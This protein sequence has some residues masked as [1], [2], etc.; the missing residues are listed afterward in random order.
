M[1][2][3]PTM[4]SSDRNGA[5]ALLA[6]RVTFEDAVNYTYRVRWQGSKNG[7]GA[8]AN[9]RSWLSLLPAG[10]YL[11]EIDARRVSA[12]VEQ[13]LARRL[14]GAT[15]NRKLSALGRVLT[16]AMQAGMIQSRPPSFPRLREK[17]GR[18][19][20]V[21]EAEVQQL[22]AHSGTDFGRLWIFLFDTGLR[23][24]EALSLTAADVD[25][26]SRSIVVRESKSGS[27]RTVPLTLRA[28]EAVQRRAIPFPVSQS[29]VNREWSSVRH[30]M[31]LT[32]DAQ[33]V[34][35]AL[36]HSCA[37]RLVKASVPLPVV[38]RWMGHKNISV[39]LR[40][41]HVGDQEVRAAATR[42]E[43]Q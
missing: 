25:V 37:T 42:L 17:G 31:G 2:A 18:T 1:T 35:H 15:I 19:R 5:S 14:S 12:V 3:M 39:T 21:S 23:V 13:L 9:A 7:E 24:S 41:A 4:S 20:V 6:H 26:A 8:L 34:P 27:P 29:Q 43:T 40:Y 11:D 28:L 32:L 30:L 38:Q 36:R 16:S 10:I 33:F 22:V